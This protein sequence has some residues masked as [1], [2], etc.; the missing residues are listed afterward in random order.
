MTECYSPV[1]VRELSQK[2]PNCWR[3]SYLNFIPSLSVLLAGSVAGLRVSLIHSRAL[4]IDPEN[5]H[6]VRLSTAAL[7]GSG[8]EDACKALFLATA[9][10]RDSINV[11]G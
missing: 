6:P 2:R 10:G 1:S 7:A 9:H 3:A 4:E 5:H 11:G 8:G